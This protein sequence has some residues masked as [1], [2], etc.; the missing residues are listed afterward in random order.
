MGVNRA[1]ESIRQAAAISR[2]NWKGV[3]YLHARDLKLALQADEYQ[4]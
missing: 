1:E 4:E 3:H 2:L